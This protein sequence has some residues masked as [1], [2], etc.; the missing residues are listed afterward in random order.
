MP[1]SYIDPTNYDTLQDLISQLYLHTHESEEQVAEWDN[2]ADIVKVL[3]KI[4]SD[5]HCVGFKYTENTDNEYFGVFVNPTISNS[6]LMTILVD[7]EEF[8]LDRYQVELDSK[9]LDLGAEYTAAYIVEDIANTMYPTAIT[10]LRAFIDEVLAKTEE[11]INI[12]NAINCNALLIWGI[13]DTLHKLTSMKYRI[14]D[15]D[16]V[17]LNKYSRTF[18]THDTLTVCADIVKK[19][20]VGLYATVKKPDMSPLQW[21]F[22]VYNDFAHEFKDI[23]D[24]LSDA[25]SL[26]GSKLM[27]AELEKTLKAL[28]RASTEVV[29]E[30][31]DLLNEARKV[32]LFKQI[33]TN[34]LKAVENQ[35]YEFKVRIKSCNDED[36]AM[37][38]LRGISANLT[39]LEDY[40]DNTPNLSESEKARW[41]ECIDQY[42]QLRR[43][44]GAKK[45]QKYNFLGNFD[46]AQLDALD[47]P[48]QQ[49]NTPNGYYANY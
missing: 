27:K 24:K 47:G 10:N 8:Q 36:E 1:R 46:Y 48:R 9:L 22:I 38:I 6:D 30:Q 28:N 32:S 16:M 39:I 4:F 2:N 3:N 37:W 17:G 7:T 13:K 23:R 19:N 11:N 25:I 20:T 14:F 34:G 15:T 40:V 18:N 49:I 21:T 43:E 12:R 5:K 42:R 35:L 29:R 45:F 44:L 33:K 26:T 41:E 31:T